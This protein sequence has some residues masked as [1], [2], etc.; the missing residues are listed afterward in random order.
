MK[1]LANDGI[2]AEG[3]TALE[4]AGHEVYTDKISQED[5]PSKINDYDVLIVRS[6]TKVNKQVLENSTR[7]KLVIRAGVGMDNVDADFAKSKGILT[8]N[9]P[10]SSSL[11]VAELVFSHLFGMVRFLHQSNREMPKVGLEKFNELKKNYADGS[12]LRGKILGIIG[13]GRIGQE[14]AK[15]AVGLGMK[16]FAYDPFVKEAT[17]PFD[18]L[19]FTP[20][21]FLFVETVT[22]DKVLLKSDFITLHLPHNEGQ[23]ALIGENEM[24]KMKKGAGIVNCARGGVVDEKALIMML[25]Q[26]YLSY[27]GLDVFLNEPKPDA[28]IL[29]HPSISIT[30]HIG[31][32]TKEAQY[33]ISLEVA[34]TVVRLLG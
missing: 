28:A 31:A 9:T 11:S 33:R 30:P 15:I 25:D 2:A 8:A 27:A 13:F 12:E 32:S 22:L 1:I 4:A 24:M 34:E 18:H 10:Q 6:A 14:V 5:L 16:I 7:L 3:K 29:N 26:G 17:L 20:A 23:S 19:P 21:P